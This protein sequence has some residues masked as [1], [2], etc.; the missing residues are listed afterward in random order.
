[1]LTSAEFLAHQLLAG[2]PVVEEGGGE[3]VVEDVDL[4]RPTAKAFEKLTAQTE[5]HDCSARVGFD[6][7]VVGALGRGRASGIG[8]GL[9]Q[10]A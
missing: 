9:L 3:P 4:L 6:V 8:E 5:P 2:E 1:V 7:N 10:F